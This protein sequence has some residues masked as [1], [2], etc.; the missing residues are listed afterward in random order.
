YVREYAYVKQQQTA[1]KMYKLVGEERFLLWAVCSIQLQVSCGQGG[2]K[3]LALAEGLLK[4][5]IASHSLH[6]PEALIVYI[7]VLEQQGKYG[8]AL[9]VLFGKL[10][11]LILIEVDRLRLQGRLL[12]QSGDNA[13]AASTFQKILESCPDDWQCFLHY[14]GCLLEDDQSWCDGTTSEPRCPP[15][16]VDK[17]PHITDAMFNSRIQDASSFVSKL[18]TEA[19]GILRGACLLLILKLRGGNSYMALIGYLACFCSDVEVFLDI[20]T[21]AEKINL[22]EKL[23]ECL[24]TMSMVPA[25]LWVKQ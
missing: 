6:E 14:L 10:G 5:H 15:K 25:N 21:P 16:S 20:L 19:S 22:L 1:I 2:D 12:A 3:L 9:E 13:A 23:K 4:K 18:E 7:S 24:G 11:S 8:D 17:L